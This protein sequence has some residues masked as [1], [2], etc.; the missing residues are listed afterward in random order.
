MAGGGEKDDSVGFGVSST[1]LP[2]DAIA[3]PTM[4]CMT[5]SLTTSSETTGGLESIVEGVSGGSLCDKA[6][7]PYV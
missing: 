2:P 4:C 1:P 7:K 5:D 6:L 3:S